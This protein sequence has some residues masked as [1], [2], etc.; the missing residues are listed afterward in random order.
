[1]KDQNK[2]QKTIIRLVRSKQELEQ[3]LHIRRVVFTEE[4]KINEKLDRDG[5][6]STAKHAIVL[7][8]NKPIGCARIRFIDGGA[9]LERIAIL[10][11]YRGKGLGIALVNYLLSYCKRAKARQVYMDSQHYLKEFYEKFGFKTKG[12]SFME[13]GRKHIIMYKNLKY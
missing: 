10:K 1:M 6:D 12:K 3:V 2:M 4:Q 8:K 13:V 7:L 5:L 9:K 11:A